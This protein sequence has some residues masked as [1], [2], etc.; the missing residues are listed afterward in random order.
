MEVNFFSHA[1]ELSTQMTVILPEKAC[2]RADGKWPTL[3]LLHGLSD[4]HSIWMRHTSIERYV[5]NLNLCVVMPQV[6]R[7]FYTDMKHGGTFW[8]FVSE[9]LPALCERM[10]PLSPLREDRFVAG[11]SMGGYGAFKLGLRCPER[12]AGAAS[13]SGAVDIVGL[14][15]PEGMEDK[16]FWS[17]IFGT[18]DDLRG[19]DDDLAAVAQRLIQSGE[20]LP[21]F[22]MACG[23]EDF[24]YQ[25]NVSFR[26]RFGK[27][28]DLTY[29]EGPGAHEWAFWDQYIQRALAFFGV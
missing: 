2:P 3:Y 21:R 18:I 1:L 23:T 22:Y 24:L 29:E 10:F 6:H 11:L 14:Y 4:D 13:L 9:E 27:G 20:Q 19:S 26:D 17:D 16:T 7:S 12:F 15:N 5:R 25:N 8:T 28:L